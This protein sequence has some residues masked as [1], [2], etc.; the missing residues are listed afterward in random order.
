MALQ[1]MDLHLH[2]RPGKTN[3]NADTLSHA[4]LT[5]H[6]EGSKGKV[7]AAL[8]APKALAKDGEEMIGLAERQNNDN[9]LKPIIEY[10]KNGNLPE[11]EKVARELTL[12]KKQYVLMDDILYH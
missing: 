6:S 9:E 4:P 8:I 7:V 10:I 11:E 5:C 2:Y 1:E 12:N 3:Q